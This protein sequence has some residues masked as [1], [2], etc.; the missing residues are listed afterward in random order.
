[1]LTH[2]QLT[3]EDRYLRAAEQHK[4]M[5][6]LIT[7]LLL[8]IGHD[9]YAAE[10]L[11]RKSS[12]SSLSQNAQQNFLMKENQRLK[13]E[14][15]RLQN[16][17]DVHVHSIRMH[18]QK[19][20]HH[21][22]VHAHGHM[23]S[24]NPFQDAAGTIGTGLQ[25]AAGTI[26][27]L[28]SAA[29]NGDMDD[30]TGQAAYIANEGMRALIHEMKAEM[31]DLIGNCDEDCFKGVMSETRTRMNTPGQAINIVY[32]G[33]KAF[34]HIKEPIRSGGGLKKM[35]IGLVFN[36]LNGLFE[37]AM[38][39]VRRYLS[40]QYAVQIRPI[41]R[42]KTA[43]LQTALLKYSAV[44]IFESLQ[45]SLVD[46][47]RHSINTACSI[48]PDLSVVIEIDFPP[49]CVVIVETILRDIRWV[50]DVA[51][52]IAKKIDDAI[53]DDKKFNGVGKYVKAVDIIDFLDHSIGEI[54]QTEY[55][56]LID[57]LKNLVDKFFDN[58]QANLV[59]H[60]TDEEKK[61]KEE[62]IVKLKKQANDLAEV[63][64]DDDMMCKLDTIASLFFILFD[65]KN[66]QVMMSQFIYARMHKSIYEK[67]RFDFLWNAF[68]EGSDTFQ[69]DGGNPDDED[70]DD[71]QA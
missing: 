43:K 14:I 61:Q 25:D 56:H 4:N 49:Y 27:W 37:W 36:S 9:V 48:L 5:S 35:L 57:A 64:C 65:K 69:A 11:L 41:F 17:V 32:I 31:R 3:K 54:V 71:N 55:Q 10:I 47:M 2:P 18:K 42:R 7:L 34:E 53:E 38:P 66:M 45:T 1:L 60:L 39:D 67:P 52:Y 12:A 15:R 6:S 29:F 40:S 24:K 30:M 16:H 33:Q 51:Y 62:T 26:G 19:S 68:D 21:V 22:G 13:K 23:A 59:R 20:H 44:N 46:S 8:I 58:E 28:A 63:S 70:P 50:H